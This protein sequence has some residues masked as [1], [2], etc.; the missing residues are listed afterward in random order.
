MIVTQ[1]AA[2]SGNVAITDIQAIGNDIELT[3][4]TFGNSTNVIQL[5]MPTID[6]SYTD[7]FTD[8]GSLFVPGSGLLITNW[9]DYG[10]ATNFP[11]RYYRIH[12]QLGPPCGP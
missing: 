3:W 1:V 7:V 12:F 9:T 2:N 5:A 11:T 8:I 6:G 10:G 4:Q